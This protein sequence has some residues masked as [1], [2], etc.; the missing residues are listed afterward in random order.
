MAIFEMV[1]MLAKN[2][3]LDLIKNKQGEFWLIDDKRDEI[4]G[5]RTKDI[6]EVSK[7]LKRISGP[8]FPSKLNRN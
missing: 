7:Y 8:A 4:S 1:A 6:I 3:E 2:V 5:T